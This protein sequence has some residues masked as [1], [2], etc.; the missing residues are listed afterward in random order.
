L[1]LPLEESGL[2]IVKAR[3]PIATEV[4]VIARSRPRIW[5]AVGGKFGML[6]VALIAMLGS[7]PLVAQ[8]SVGNVA[9]GLFAD[10]VLVLSLH[11]ARP[12]ERPVVLGFLLA[13]TDFGLG[14][15]VAIDGTRSLVALQL[16]VWIVTLVFVSVTILEAIFD[17]E[18]VT[19]ETLQAALCI[20]LLLGLFWVFLYALIELL[21]PGS[22]QSQQGFQVTW[23]VDRSRRAE[24]LR[25]LVFSYKSLTGAGY[26]DLSP[27]TGFTSIATC[28]EAMMGQIYLAVVIARLVG[29]QASQPRSARIVGSGVE[30]TDPPAEEVTGG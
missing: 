15:L 26:S 22:F 7:A 8:K 13:L 10:V 9:L 20:Y 3:L 6:L 25:L 28:L 12:G 23:S 5:N 21:A 1:P 30:A 14:R 4:K 29:I 16:I 2:T 11:A 17:S 24:F 18:S 27:A 19:V